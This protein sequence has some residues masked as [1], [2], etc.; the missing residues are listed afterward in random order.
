MSWNFT[1]ATVLLAAPLC[2]QPSPD[3][4][5]I[6]Q[7]VSETY[8]SARKYRF[9]MK[10]SGEEA[11]TL[12]IAVQKPNRFHL[13]ANGRVLDG[14]DAFSNITMVSDGGSAWNYVPDLQQY[15]RKPVSLPLLDTEP[16]AITPETFVLQAD[17][18]FLRRYAELAKASDRARFLRQESLGGI[19]C[20]V[21]EL[22]AP[23]PGYRDTYTWWVDPRRS[24]VLR[25]DTVP[26]SPRRPRSSVVYSLASVDE[27]LPDELFHFSPPAGARQVNQLEE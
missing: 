4:S 2:A 9:A 18:V 10:K 1:A 8:A 15:T 3:V 21:I 19:Q 6:L 22:R 20:Y 16:P 7:R 5:A 12:D 11:G 14:V 23:R 26:E 27:A 24:L 17:V 13:Q 25:E